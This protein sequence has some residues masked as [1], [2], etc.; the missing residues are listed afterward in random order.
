MS[1]VKAKARLVRRTPAPIVRG[2]SV[3]KTKASKFSASKPAVA[4]VHVKKIGFMTYWSEPEIKARQTAPAAAASS[5][6]GEKGLETLA[7]L[8]IL[9]SLVAALER[10]RAVGRSVRFTVDVTPRGQAAVGPVETIVA[11]ADPASNE[12]ATSGSDLARALAAAR[13]RGQKRVADILSAEDMLSADQLARLLGTTRM[14][15][16]TKRRKRQLLA[17][18]GAKRGFRFPRW[19]ID[20]G[21]KP[22]AEL[23]DLF[24][25]LG[26]SPWAVYRFLIQHHAELGGLTG[27]EALTKG[28]SAEV[29]EAAESVLETFS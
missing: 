27:R 10:A 23:P 2:K 19:Q 28:R 18:E 11:R 6:G 5:A 1:S 25:R 8:R 29:I 7:R 17:I 24:D 4:K 3:A 22:F 14:T 21:G 26:G 20:E 13:E 15:I 16:N 9:E 12:Q